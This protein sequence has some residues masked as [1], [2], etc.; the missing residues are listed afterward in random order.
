[1]WIGNGDTAGLHNSG[2]DY[3]DALLPAA[4]TYLAAVARRALAG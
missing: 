1:M 4:A 3:N 2:Y